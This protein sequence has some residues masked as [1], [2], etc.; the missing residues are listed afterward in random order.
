[1]KLWIVVFYVKAPSLYLEVI[2]KLVTVTIL[3]LCLFFYHFS[4]IVKQGLKTNAWGDILE[5]GVKR[6][7]R[8]FL[9]GMLVLGLFI[10][11]V[12]QLDFLKKVGFSLLSKENI[13]AI[14]NLMD[15]VLGTKSVSVAF[16]II[17]TWTLL[18]IEISLIFFFLGTVVI[19]R[20]FLP[21]IKK[22]DF[23]NKIDAEGEREQKIPFIKRKIFYNFAN[24]KI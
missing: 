7:L 14:R 1:M 3:I 17:T 23:A 9:V 16:G 15:I 20:F 11:A 22:E 6:V 4:K 13:Q 21:F 12:S 19:G 2:M 8:F 24:L 5:N 10:L 18:I